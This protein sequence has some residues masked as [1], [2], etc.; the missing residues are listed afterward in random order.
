MI[1]QIFNGTEIRFIEKDG[2]HWAVASDISKA[3]GLSLIHI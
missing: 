3:L 1:K 2:E